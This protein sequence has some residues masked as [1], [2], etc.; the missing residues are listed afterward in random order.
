ML[1]SSRNISTRMNVCVEKLLVRC[2]DIKHLLACFRFLNNFYRVQILLRNALSDT[3]TKKMFNL[4]SQD[5]NLE[6][7]MNCV[8]FLGKRLGDYDISNEYPT[9]LL[10]RGK[11]FQRTS[12]H[13]NRDTLYRLHP[14]M[15]SPQVKVIRD[16]K[17]A[18]RLLRDTSFRERSEMSNEFMLKRFGVE[19]ALS[20]FDSDWRKKSLKQTTKFIRASDDQWKSLADT[21]RAY[22]CSRVLQLGP[23]QTLNLRTLVQHFVL[24]ISL[25][26]NPKIDSYLIDERVAVIVSDINKLLQ[27]P[28]E[29]EEKIITAK[30]ALLTT[31]NKMLGHSDQR[32]NVPP[33]ENLLDHVFVAYD[34]MQRV[35]LRCLLELRFR[36]K[37]ARNSQYHLPAA[38][39]NTS[40]RLICNKFLENPQN[41]TS[42][43]GMLRCLHWDFLCRTQSTKAYD[44]THHRRRLS[45]KPPRVLLKSTLSTY[46]EIRLTGEERLFFSNLRDGDIVTLSMRPFYRL[47]PE[48]LLVQRAV[49]SDLDSLEYLL[50]LWSPR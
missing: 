22:V 20:I 12:R 47:V 36:P 41:R 37:G 11:S 15:S 3:W 9:C 8:E 32:S 26:I 48:N 24:R 17:E 38:L 50:Q 35:V 7:L 16:I 25:L 31:V 5:T 34:A 28:D 21:S 33:R 2:G 4:Q 18:K 46:I 40:V 45:E 14:T 10:L 6:F 30:N 23:G 39:M 19:N 13:Y 44:Y 42:S 49:D 43:T 27:M 29:A 1:Y